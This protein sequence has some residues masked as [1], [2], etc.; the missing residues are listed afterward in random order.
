MAVVDVDIGPIDDENEDGELAA[1]DGVSIVA[2]L[3]HDVEDNGD[4]MVNDFMGDIGEDV[5]EFVVG[6]DIDDDDDDG[7]AIIIA[8]TAV[9]PHNVII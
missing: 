1:V 2:G 7:D 9:K 5:D 8:A 3:E 6:S 4:V